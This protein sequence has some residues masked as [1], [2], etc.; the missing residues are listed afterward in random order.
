MDAI[1]SAHPLKPYYGY[2]LVKGNVLR[3]VPLLPQ[4]VELYPPRF[5]ISAAKVKLGNKI[6]KKIDGDI[7]KKAYY[8]Q[9]PIHFDII[10]A[11]K[12][13]GTIEDPIQ[14]E[15]N[16]MIGAHAIVKSPE[17]PSAFPCNVSVNTD[18]VV[19]YL[20]LRT[21]EILDDGT[22]IIT[23]DEQKSFI[24]YV[25]LALN[26]IS[27]KLTFNVIP[28]NPTNRQYLKYMQLMQRANSGEEVMLKVLSLNQPLVL[29]TVDHK[30]FN[31]WD[32]EIEFLKKIIAIEDYFNTTIVIPEEITVD[33]HIVINHLVDL[34]EGSYKGSWNKFE[35]KP[36]SVKLIFSK[37]RKSP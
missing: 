2:G 24:F 17:F 1:N 28:H 30:E 7:F 14:E 6:I 23:N 27:K 36:E 21:K 18:V 31:Q 8:H 19:D 9:I 20:L 16:E 11:K 4:S 29:G 22:Y 26:P 32:A 33:D 25:Q 35:F 15:A 12:Y 10:A 5:D 37:A 3:S 13:L 34:I